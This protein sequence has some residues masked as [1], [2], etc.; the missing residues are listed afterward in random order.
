MKE[1]SS[2]RNGKSVLQWLLLAL[3]LTNVVSYNFSEPKSVYQVEQTFLGQTRI[4]SA[5][6]IAQISYF[7]CAKPELPVSC[8]GK[9]AQYQRIALLCQKHHSQTE[10]TISTSPET[11]VL[12]KLAL[13]FAIHKQSRLAE[14]N[15]IS[16]S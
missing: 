7:H 11:L 16:V 4:R 5:G 2:I 6:K 15:F 12:A 8:F 10:L 13:G 14:E 9:K 1:K 3:L